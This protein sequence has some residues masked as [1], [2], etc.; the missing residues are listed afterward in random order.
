MPVLDRVDAGVALSVLHGVDQGNRDGG[1]LLEEVADL[2][3][4]EAANLA[5]DLLDVGGFVLGLQEGLQEPLHD[6]HEVTHDLFL[7]VLLVSLHHVFEKRADDLEILGHNKARANLLHTEHEYREECVLHL[8]VIRMLKGLLTDREDQL[9][10]GLLEVLERQL[11][12]SLVLVAEAAPWHFLLVLVLDIKDLSL[13]LQVLEEGVEEVG[14]V[15]VVHQFE[16]VVLLGRHV[17]V[18]REVHQQLAEVVNA[19]LVP[20]DFRLDTET[21]DVFPARVKQVAELRNL[22]HLA[23]HDALQELAQ[24][25][26]RR[27][28]VRHDLCQVLEQ[29]EGANDEA[30]VELVGLQVKGLPVHAEPVLDNLEVEEGLLGGLD[31]PL[32]L[33]LEVLGGSSHDLL[34]MAYPS[35]FFDLRDGAPA[36]Q[37][38]VVVRVNDILFLQNEDAVDGQPFLADQALLLASEASTAVHAEISCLANI[39]SWHVAVEATSDSASD[40][41]VHDSRRRRLCGLRLG[42]FPDLLALADGVL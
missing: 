40:H 18:K 25:L 17:L 21:K 8:G 20:L 24:A 3:R 1:K 26:Q 11:G 10:H 37:E 36:D 13:H 33:H 30:L 31:D 19:E 42:S 4:H 28:F 38:A 22:R 39:R 15:L 23:R 35:E 7:L 16:L 14:C 34:L 29:L 2:R 5:R 12:E 41:A 32:F 27:L 9:L 6:G